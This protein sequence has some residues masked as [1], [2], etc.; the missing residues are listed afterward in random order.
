MTMNTRTLFLPLVNNG[1]TSRVIGQLASQQ[2]LAYNQAVNI[3]NREPNIPK[4]AHKNSTF[5]LNKR[6][7]AWRNENLDKA[8]APYHIHQQ[9]SEAAFLANERMADQR[10]QRLARIASAIEA[11]EQPHPRDTRPHRRTLKHRSRKHGTQTLTIRSAQFIKPK[12]RYTFTVTGVDH[13]FRTRRALPG[14]ILSIHFVEIPD[15]RRSA[16]APLEARHYQLHVSVKCD[17]PKPADL[18]DASIDEYQGM[19]DG[20]K[21]HFAFSDGTRFSFRELYPSRSP[22]LERRALQGKQKNSKRRRRSERQH[23][24]RNRRR[25]ADKLRQ[26]NAA[27]IEQLASTK[28]AAIA[29]ESKY[30]INLMRSAHG[31]GRKAKA[32]LNRALANAALGQNQRI[33]ANQGQKRGIHI[34]PVP[35]PGTSQT[36]PRCGYRRRKNRETQA[37]FRCQHCGWLG[38]ADHSAAMIIRNRGFV[39][40]TERIHGY[41]PSAEVAPTGWQEQPSGTGQPALLPRAQ[42]TPKP[43]RNATKPSRS[44]RGQRSGS[45]ALG[46]TTQVLGT[47]RPDAGPMQPPDG[48]GSALETGPVQGAQTGLL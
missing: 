18:A 38:H 1:A 14:N 28:P 24:T 46:R 12:G 31:P 9:G 8:T 7:T 40:T 36:C 19:D 6:I 35:A 27:A 4:R 37:I 21:N 10:L 22:H 26:V 32:S 43:K 47:R 23:L 34:I 17:D 13:V 42:S 15:C 2:R 41:T 25:H 3:L 11:D 29:V 48:K 45:G 39:R 33:L 20:V 30:V 5:G 16:N 44:P